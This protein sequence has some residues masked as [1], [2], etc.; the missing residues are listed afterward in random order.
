[1]KLSVVPLALPRRRSRHRFAHTW[2]PSSAS[3]LHT[4]EL[5]RYLKRTHISTSC[6][7]AG[8]SPRPS[9]IIV[10]TLRLHIS[11]RI[12][13][14]SLWAPTHTPPCSPVLSRTPLPPSPILSRTFCTLRTC[15][16]CLV[17]SHALVCSLVL[18]RTISFSPPCSLVPSRALSAAPILSRTPSVLSRTLSHAFSCS[19]FTYPTVGR[20]FKLKF[21][22]RVYACNISLGRAQIKPTRRG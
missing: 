12:A 20:R 8:A 21:E 10:L 9:E 11:A 2:A 3:C 14:E 22:D 5:C 1:M 19:P 17:L 18:S 16:C 6:L 4:Q 13:L 15:L 7:W